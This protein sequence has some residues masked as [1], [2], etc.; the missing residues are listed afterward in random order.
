VTRQ[1]LH[2]VHSTCPDV[3]IYAL[4]DLDPDGIAI[5][6]TYKLGSRSLNHESNVAIPDLTWL[7]PK[8]RDLLDPRTMYASV[9]WTDAERSHTI[10]SRSDHDHASM[11][12]DVPHD[13]ELDDNAVQTLRPLTTSDRKKAARLLQKIED[14]FCEEYDEMDLRHELQVLLLLNLKAEIQAM[15]EKGM[16]TTW[17]DIRLPHATID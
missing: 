7:G 5:M 6:C 14:E 17:L 11:S 9:S 13:H 8:T 4:V 15:E 2:L 1:F 10:S 3:P 16:L 12:T